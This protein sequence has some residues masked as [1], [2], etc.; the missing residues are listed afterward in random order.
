M[1]EAEAENTHKADDP[2]AST[3]KKARHQTRRVPLP[4][5]ADAVE[6]I[7]GTSDL[8]F[9]KGFTS[10]I[11]Y[12]SPDTQAKFVH[13]IHDMKQTMRTNDAGMSIMWEGGDRA[14]D[15]FTH[16]VL[17]LAR[18]A[19]CARLVM[20]TRET[21][22]VAT[23]RMWEECAVA[24]RVELVCVELPSDVPRRDIGS[25]FLSAFACAAGKVRVVCIGGDAQVYSDATRDGQCGVGDAHDVDPDKK[26][27]GTVSDV[28]A[29]GVPPCKK[30][31]WI[32][33]DVQRV[34]DDGHVEQFF[35]NLPGGRIAKDK[36]MV[37]VPRRSSGRRAA[38][39]TAR[40][41]EARTKARE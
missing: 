36:T 37:P 41:R 11:N 7:V 21:T 40:G 18:K 33:V 39:A 10:G 14:T 24:L 28:A 16:A 5:T 23:V 9:V 25:A 1:A 38:Q 6:A 20:C 32:I 31:E 27:D 4:T 8:L 13:F 15:S 19:K 29:G 30:T 26:E 34:G 3:A 35:D 22:S 2:V 17:E 12:N